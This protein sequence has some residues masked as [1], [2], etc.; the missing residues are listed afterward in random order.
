MDTSAVVDDE[1]EKTRKTAASSAKAG[2]GHMQ[3]HQPHQESACGKKKQPRTKGRSIP[4]FN[5]MGRSGEYQC[6]NDVSV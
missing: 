3:S 2:V 1:S 5:L 6:D 4:R